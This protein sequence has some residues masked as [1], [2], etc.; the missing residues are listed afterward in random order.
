MR[1][2]TL[3]LCCI[4]ILCVM[5]YYWQRVPGQEYNANIEQEN[6]N[7]QYMMG[8][9]YDLGSGVP[10]DY[11]K[12]AEWHQ[13][14]AEQGHAQAQARLNEMYA[15]GCDTCPMNIEDVR[16][17]ARFTNFLLE[18]S[19]LICQ[20]YKNGSLELEQPIIS[21]N[22]RSLTHG[23]EKWYYES[24]NLREEI[25]YK[26]GKVVEGIIKQY[27]ESGQLKSEAPFK[28]G[29]R[30]GISKAY[31]ESGKLESERSYKNFKLD[32]FAIYYDEN[33]R[34]TTKHLYKEGI[35]IKYWVR[36]TGH[37]EFD[38]NKA[39]IK[40]QFI[41]ELDELVRFMRNPYGTIQIQ[42]HTDSVGSEDYN[43]TLSERRAASVKQYLVSK[44]VD[45][46]LIAIQG[47]GDT[48]PL[49]TNDTAEGRAENRRTEVRFKTTLPIN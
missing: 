28:E 41:P 44:G 39:D 8:L 33:G 34:T 40:P 32:G 16:N 9:R 2:S 7:A 10:Q 38:F 30:E 1:K 25:P 20:Y 45:P 14:A 4:F 3:C 18:S 29:N 48:N 6:V 12:A 27:Y 15:E 37:I 23:M 21:K 46:A 43:Q 24:G 19:N 42:G 22:G 5:Y 49:A 47:Y 36:G 17:D 13:K 35:Q 26:E 31:Y 11:V